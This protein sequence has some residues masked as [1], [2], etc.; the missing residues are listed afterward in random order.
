MDEA[1]AKRVLADMLAR[2]TAG[3]LLH[4]L[5]EVLRDRS[6]DQNAPSLRDAVGALYVLGVGLDALSPGPGR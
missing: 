4:L 1:Q 2:Y 5:A 3:S 6:G